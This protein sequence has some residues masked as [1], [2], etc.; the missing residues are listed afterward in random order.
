MGKG[1]DSRVIIGNLRFTVTEEELLEA[2]SK[3]CTILHLSIPRR[4]NNDASMGLGVVDVPSDED[5]D[6]MHDLL[7]KKTFLGRVCY[8]QFDDEQS[9]RR[10][11][12]PRPDFRDDYRDRESSPPLR[13]RSPPRPEPGS[14]P[15]PPP[16]HYSGGERRRYADD[17]DPPDRWR[18]YDRDRP[19]RFYD[20]DF[21]R[22]DYERAPR[23]YD[24][25][26]PDRA[27][28]DYER[29]PRDY[30]RRDTDR[31][32]RD[33]D[34]APRDT[35]RGYERDRREREYER[36]VRDYDRDRPQ[37]DYER[38]RPRQPTRV[39]GRLDDSPPLRDH[40]DSPRVSP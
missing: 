27:S 33:Y 17:R 23:D 35:G 20:R 12:P 14:P 28:R 32:N 24:R 37:R 19:R 39:R 40:H 34:R 21:D 29:V 38:D 3:Y 30:D 9:K 25:R 13:P 7:N 4:P 2:L 15:R 8:I 36:P 1:D 5:A 18:D 11:P 10:R 22:R 6:R 31:P 16:G 26:E